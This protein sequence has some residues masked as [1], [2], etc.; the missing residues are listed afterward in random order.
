MSDPGIYCMLSPVE[1]ITN[2]D[3]L[4]KP[5]LRLFHL[6][7]SQLQTITSN[8]DAGVSNDYVIVLPGDI[9]VVGQVL[10]A[11]DVQTSGNSVTVHTGW[12]N[13]ANGNTSANA[14]VDIAGFYAT[15]T[16]NLLLDG[17]WM[18]VNSWVTSVS[19]PAFSLLGD[20]TTFQA[21]YPSKVNGSVKIGFQSN[22]TIGSRNVRVLQNGSPI[23]LV[24]QQPNPNHNINTFVSVPFYA[25]LSAADNLLVQIQYF[26]VSS[27]GFPV[28]M[29]PGQINSLMGI[30]I[31]Y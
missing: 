4:L 29:I 2:D 17:T 3:P 14:N 18:N 5:E 7:S 24:T 27:N 9:P 1:I 26:D 16:I 31:V 28:F 15:N 19:S 11:I 13:N 23:S 12:S 10:T 21:I 22:A 25:Q 30:N 8:T 6:P 20:Q